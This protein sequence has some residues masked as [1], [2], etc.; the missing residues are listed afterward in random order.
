MVRKLNAFRKE[1]L[2]CFIDDTNKKKAFLPGV[3]HYKGL[4]QSFAK[5]SKPVTSMRK[6]R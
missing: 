6:C 3:G 4:E 1:K 5:L 2:H